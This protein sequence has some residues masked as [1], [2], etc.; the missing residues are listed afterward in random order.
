VRRYYG[1]G[2]ADDWA[3]LESPVHHWRGRSKKY[4]LTFS[5]CHDAKRASELQEHDMDSPGGSAQRVPPLSII[6]LA[7][8]VAGLGAF[9]ASISAGARTGSVVWFVLSLVVG[10]ALVPVVFVAGYYILAAGFAL[11]LLVF[12]TEI[13]VSRGMARARAALRATVLV[14]ALVWLACMAPAVWRAGTAKEQYDALVVAAVIPV[15]LIAGLNVGRLGRLG[16][17]WDDEVVNRGRG[18]QG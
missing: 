7:L 1:A 18:D 10:V 17:W 3:G 6:E 12:A 13:P 15:G 11:C 16:R 8:F 4:V 14:T 5:N 9:A 2:W